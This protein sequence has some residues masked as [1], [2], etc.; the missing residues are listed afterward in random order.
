MLDEKHK[1][2]HGSMDKAETSPASASQSTPQHRGKRERY[3]PKSPFM[4]HQRH[5]PILLHKLYHH[6]LLI[7]KEKEEVMW[8]RNKEEESVCQM[9][10]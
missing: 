1:Q 4:Q 5:W 6:P 3:T 2:M 9:M 8:K 10:W 7:Q